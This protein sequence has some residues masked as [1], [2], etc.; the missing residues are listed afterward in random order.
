MFLHAPS[1]AVVPLQRSL[2]TRILRAWRRANRCTIRP[3]KHHCLR[4]VNPVIARCEPNSISMSLEA[5]P[6]PPSVLTEA[7]QRASW[8]K[9]MGLWPERTTHQAIIALSVVFATLL[10]QLIFLDL[11]RERRNEIENSGATTK[12]LANVLTEHAREN[13]RRIDVLMEQGAFLIRDAPLA[14]LE[15]P[16]ILSA[17]LKALIPFDGFLLAYRVFD[18]QGVAGITA[19]AMPLPELPQE[20]I[21]TLIKTHSDAPRRGLLFSGA[22]KPQNSSQWLVPVSYRLT[23]SDGSFKGVLVG[24]FDP[25]VFQKFYRAIDTGPNGFI[26]LFSREGWV[27]ARV[28]FVEK[29]MARNWADSPMFREHLPKLDANTVR[30]VVAADGIERIYSYQTMSDFP[31]V[32]SVGSSLTDSLAPWRERALI[33]LSLHAIVLLALLGTTVAM[34]R[35]LKRRNAAEAALKLSEFSVQASSQA[36]LW[37]TP[38][39]RI[40]HV[41][42]AACELYG[43]TEAQLLGKQ[44]TELSS[45]LTAANWQDR[46]QALREAKRFSVET[47]HINSAGKVLQVEVD[48]NWIEFDG[49]EYQFVFVRD[50]ATRKA[51]EHSIRNL[52]FYDPLTGLPNRRFLLDRLKVA[53]AL[54]MRRQTRAALMFIDM[55]NFKSINDTLGHDYGDLL[56]KQVATRLKEALREGDTVARL[57]GDEFVVLLEDLSLDGPLARQQAQTKAEAIRHALSQPYPSDKVTMHSSPSVGVTLFGVDEVEDTDLPLKRADLA[58]YAAKKAGRNRVCF[59]EEAMGDLV[60]RG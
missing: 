57:G 6:N 1:L 11:S 26:T 17:S 41:N 9:R 28:P 38:D 44:M 15:K 42:T 14:A 50:I 45:H 36:T 32:V 19:G 24:L 35:Q 53:M 39:A 16:E 59:Y 2:A 34:V 10:S 25:S 29:V 7:A 33:E 31:V 47:E 56:L 12:N 13:L 60:A 27:L 43:F 48:I 23:G 52:A 4:R 8:I 37:I 18:P 20:T 5:M 58:M 30:Q 21:R 3:N 51:A 22:Y 54:S 55:D 40:T 49:R 46:W